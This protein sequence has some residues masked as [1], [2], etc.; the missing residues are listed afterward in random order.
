MS[1]PE[2]FIARWSRRKREAAED[3][4]ATKSSAAPDGAAGS[5][6]PSEDQSDA[7]LGRSGARRSPEAAFDPTKL[8]PIETIAAESDVTAFLAP[9]VPPELTRAALRRAWAADPKI[10]DFIGLSEN[11]WDFNAPGAMTGF[12]SLEMTDELRQQIARM[13]G[14]SVAT[15]VTDSPAQTSAEA[16]GKP[17]PAETST[18]P[19]ATAA[20]VS[21][22]HVQSNAGPSSNNRIGAQNE[23]HTSEAPSQ[24][25]KADIAS[26]NNSENTDNDQLI[27]KRPHGS[28]LPK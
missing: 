5:A 8:P 27:E 17:L 20:E 21:T 19:V 12:G 13:V 22:Q 18:E 15:E 7:A 4:E 24:R 28:A 11:S 14:R 2:N 3:A 25:S 6:H 10:R 9:G 1:Q 23:P 16:Q 26:Q